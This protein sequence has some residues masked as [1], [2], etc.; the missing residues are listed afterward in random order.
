[1]WQFKKSFLFALLVFALISCGGGHEEPAN[2]SA[3]DINV[4]TSKPQ[5][6]YPLDVAVKFTSLNAAENVGV[7]LF[8]VKNNG[9]SDDELQ[10][11]PL[12]SGILEQVEAGANVLQLHIDVPSNIDPPGEYYLVAVIDPAGV[13]SELDKDDNTVSTEITLE[14]TPGQNIKLLKLE[15]DRSALLVNTSTYEEQVDGTAGN[16]YNSDAGGT[17]TVA[18]DGLGATQ[19][20]A[21]DAF[22]KLRIMRTDTNTTYEL[23]LYLWNTSMERYTN[24]YG[25]D[26]T[27]TSSRTEVEWLPMG[28][29]NPLLA[30]TAIDNASVDDVERASARIEFYLPGK[31]GQ[32]LVDAARHYPVCAPPKVC[33]SLP[34]P[35]L[36]ADVI[37]QLT[38]F[39]KD[40]PVSETLYDESAAMAVLNFAI[41]VD[42]RPSNTTLVDQDNSDNE[43]CEPI[44][45]FLPPIPTP[46]P[47]DDLL[48]LPDG[49]P[50]LGSTAYRITPEAK[51]IGVPKS[52][53]VAMLSF[54]L[55]SGSTSMMDNHGYVLE[56]HMNIPITIFGKEFDLLK[57]E[58]GAQ[59]IPDAYAGKPVDEKTEYSIETRFAGI[60]LDSDTSGP[61]DDINSTVTLEIGYSK[62]FPDAKEKDK[63][64]GNVGV[65]PLTVKL[66]AGVAVGFG[67][68]IPGL[69]LT[70]VNPAYSLH[71]A[72]GPYANLDVSLTLSYGNDLISGG[73]EGGATLLN[74]KLEYANSVDIT[75]HRPSDP[76]EFT[77]EQGPKTTFLFTGPE[78][79]VNL[80]VKFTPAIKVCSF[81]PKLPSIK[82]TYTL[83]K[84]GPLF[85]ISDILYQK[86]NVNLD[87]V[88][89]T[90]GEPIYYSTTE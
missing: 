89:P 1:M 9:N 67:Y 56:H 5:I 22:A 87:V 47:P 12:S 90:D 18:A 40:L 46:P 41:C 7:S 51:I 84:S 69:V 64:K 75:L 30:G 60:L 65:G 76:A 8:F 16:V 14:S 83:W 52:G 36:T 21:I 20:I 71:T 53:A 39:L 45:V 10:Q 74:V 37:N 77:I 79:Y 15:L 3:T 72:G 6:G 31:L 26:P 23:P 19:T 78:G 81:C 70:A 35:D 38:V 88:I 61:S 62:E 17:I 59:L 82:Y 27:G 58:S 25:V 86:A 29:F 73:I 54:I 80:F 32:V 50:Y 44:V 28:T 2:F 66:E 63:N 49:V 34:P 4:L 42:I 13:V 85:E 55:D 43:S 48:I 68:E 33:A 24:A 11:Y 57:I